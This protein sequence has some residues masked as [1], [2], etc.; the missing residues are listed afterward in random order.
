MYL[1]LLLCTYVADV[2]DVV[3]AEHCLQMLL[4]DTTWNQGGTD[5]HDPHTFP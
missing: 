4:P 5:C 2:G 3:L 1:I